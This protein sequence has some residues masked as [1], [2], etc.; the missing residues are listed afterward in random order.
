MRIVQGLH[1]HTY[2]DIRSAVKWIKTM[3]GVEYTPQDIIDLP[4]RIWIYLN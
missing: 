3:F 2:T 4:S 1:E